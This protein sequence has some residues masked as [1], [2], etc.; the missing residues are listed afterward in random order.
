M[1][2]HNGRGAHRR[3]AHNFIGKQADQRMQEIIKPAQERGLNALDV[4]TFEV[5]YYRRAN[6]SMPCS[7]QKAP[8]PA[9]LDHSAI[10]SGAVPRHVQPVIDFGDDGEIVIDHNNNLFGTRS[11]MGD[12]DDD[13]GGHGQINPEE[14]EEDDFSGQSQD[15]VFALSTDCGICYRNG[16][17]PGYE[18]YG[19]DRKVLAGAHIFDTYGYTLDTSAS[20]HTFNVIDPDGAYVDF[21]IEVPKYFQKMRY[22]L[23]NNQHFLPDDVLFLPTQNNQLLTLAAVRMSAGHELLVRVRADQFTHLVIEFDL[24]VEPVRAGLAQDN[25]ATDWTMFDTMGSVSVVL[26]MTIDSV[27]TSDVLYIPSRK[28]TLKVSD[29]TYLR[30]ARDKNMDWQVQTRVLQ[31]QEALKRIFQSNV[32]R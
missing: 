1:T 27:E 5:L 22:S 2:I 21:V 13:D 20:P 7:C 18:L 3:H 29:V 23:R 14:I 11:T 16:M 10:D 28:R 19:H 12:H 31:P 15:K 4:D 8:A 24:G 26:P 25:K 6:S 30:T 32:L 9:L 17:L